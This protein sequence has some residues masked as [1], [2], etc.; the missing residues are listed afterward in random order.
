MESL[1]QNK[2]HLPKEAKIVDSSFEFCFFRDFAKAERINRLEGS[3]RKALEKQTFDNIYILSDD[4]IVIVEAK[5]HQK[6]S[7]KQ[8]IL[9]DNAKKIIKESKNCSV[10]LIGLHSS[11]YE[12]KPSTIEKFNATITWTELAKCFGDDEVFKRANEIY[13]N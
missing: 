2:L 5:A 8:I 9:L 4:S 7:P 12:P 11:N 1:L 3:Q 13:N 6:F 10:Y